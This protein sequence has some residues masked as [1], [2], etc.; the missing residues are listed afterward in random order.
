MQPAFILQ[1]SCTF[2]LVFIFTLLINPLA[3][4]IALVDKPDRQ[5]KDHNGAIPLTGGIAIYLG[6]LF[7]LL[8]YDVDGENI[9]FLLATGLMVLAGALDDRFNLNITLRI[10]LEVLA[11][12]IMVFGANL[13]VG[14]LGNLLGTGE[15]HMPFWIAYPFTVVAVFGIVNAINMI[16]GLDGLAGG[17]TLFALMLLILVTQNSPALAEFGGCLI[18]GLL[19]FL[20]FNFRLHKSLPKIFLGDSGSK[21]LGLALVW[22]V[23]ETAQTDAASV[24]GIQPATAL[25]IMGLPL[26]DMVATTV[27]RVKKGAHPFHADRTHI[28]HIL[29]RAGYSKSTVLSLILALAMAINLLGIFLQY[30]QVPEVMQFVIFFAIYFLYSA[31]I[32][33]AWKLSKWLKNSSIETVDRAATCEA[34]PTGE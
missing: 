31:T 19:A 13:W 5:R 20:L 32:Q 34:K 4:R 25:F 2:A 23:I 9:T 10:A 1:L 27:R 3:S 28:H 24:Y 11:A 17:V 16:D 6:L 14:N 7:F 29:Q 12:S 15:F 18:G 21:L 22:I 8:L 33:H 26:I 30:L